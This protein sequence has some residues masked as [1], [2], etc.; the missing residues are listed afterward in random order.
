M[1]DSDL[2]PDAP[3]YELLEDVPADQEDL[4]FHLRRIGRPGD[5][6][7]W[8]NTQVYPNRAQWVGPLSDDEQAYLEYFSLPDARGRLVITTADTL[9]DWEK[10]QAR[11]LLGSDPSAFQSYANY[12]NRFK[13][14]RHYSVTHPA[15]LTLATA[16]Y[17]LSRD[18]HPLLFSLER[19]YQ[20]GSGT[21]FLT[22]VPVSRVAAGVEFIAVLAVI[23]VVNTGVSMTRPTPVPIRQGIVRQD[24]NYAQKTYG[25]RFSTEE[26]SRFGL[27]DGRALT[28]DEVAELI[29]G[30]L[31]PR[32]VPVNI[33]HRNGYQLMLNTRSSQALEKAGIP[34]SQW[35]G[36]DRT[37]DPL[38]EFLVWAQLRRNTLGPS[39]IPVVRPKTQ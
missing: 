19:G 3:A 4:L 11:E 28:V 38:Y 26:S 27:G 20:I 24:A 8:W 1:T 7:Q 5:A 16:L 21:E 39:G 10:Q 30:G 17:R 18:M 25:P 35:Y 22:D 37:G 6:T 32:H 2:V 31:S 33:I 15:F 29:R 14:L 13:I 34:R 36:I 12:A 23:K 9:N